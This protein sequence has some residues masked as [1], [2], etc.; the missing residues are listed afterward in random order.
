MIIPL[1]LAAKIAIMVAFYT[2]EQIFVNIKTGSAMEI[3]NIDKYAYMLFPSR[4]NN[5]DTKAV[6]MINSDDEFL[7]YLNFLTD[8]APLPKPEK[9]DGIYHFHYHYKDLPVIVDMFRNEKPVFLFYMDN[10][11]E[12]CRISTSM[13]PVGEGEG[14][15]TEK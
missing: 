4:D 15:V 3:K 9:T 2:F 6:V 11:K 14:I 7:G 13:E 12:S 1:I 8:G 10:D 5:F